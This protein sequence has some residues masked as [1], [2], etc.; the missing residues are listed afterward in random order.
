MKR[1]CFQLQ[2]E[3]IDDCLCKVETVDQFNNQKIYPRL[4]SL[5]VND[6]FRYYKV[7]LKHEC[8]F[9]TDDSRCAIRFCHVEAC[10]DDEVPNGIKVSEYTSLNHWRYRSE[11]VRLR[12]E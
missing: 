12:F 7:N 2:K 9:W 10:R 6:H 3:L 5:L 8:P 1:F 4:K 11:E